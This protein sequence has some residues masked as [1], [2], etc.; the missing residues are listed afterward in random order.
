MKWGRRRLGT[1]QLQAIPAPEPA[2]I[3][4]WRWI[5][6]DD[7]SAAVPLLPSPFAEVCPLFWKE[8]LPLASS[9]D[10][11]VRAE[12]PPPTPASSRR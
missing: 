5:D 7:L 6:P 2:P 11:G 1:Q 3:E 4:L 12:P 9:A 10:G 8:D